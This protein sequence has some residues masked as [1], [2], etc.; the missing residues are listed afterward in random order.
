MS[1]FRQSS[2]NSFG[3]AK[4]S[5][6][7]QKGVLYLTTHGRLPTLNVLFPVY[8]ALGHSLDTLVAPIDSVLFLGQVGAT[9]HFFSFLYADIA[10]VIVVRLTH[11]A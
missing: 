2:V 3:K 10:R 8:S 5:F 1:I 7:Y 4:V 9:F 6:H 11:Q